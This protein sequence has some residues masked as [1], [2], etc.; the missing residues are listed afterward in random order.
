LTKPPC[1]LTRKSS[2]TICLKRNLDE[3]DWKCYLRI[4][5]QFICLRT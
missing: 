1:L 5:L 2:S 3:A 4:L